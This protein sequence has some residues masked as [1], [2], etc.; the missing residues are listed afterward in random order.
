MVHT[1]RSKDMTFLHPRNLQKLD[2]T[3]WAYASGK[4]NGFYEGMQYMHGQVVQVVSVSHGVKV[5]QEWPCSALE[6]NGL[7]DQRGA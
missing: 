5:P 2:L 3:P 6:W 4:L 1:C 7:T